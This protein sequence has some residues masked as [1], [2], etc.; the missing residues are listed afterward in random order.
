MFGAVETKAQAASADTFKHRMEQLDDLEEVSM[1]AC[2]WLCVCV[3][4][5]CVACAG[6]CEGDADSEPEGMWQRLCRGQNKV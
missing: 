1:C 3:H 4:V 6:L 5:M 2:A